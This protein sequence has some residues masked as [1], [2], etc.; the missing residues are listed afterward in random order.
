MKDSCLYLPRDLQ[1]RENEVKHR[2][3]SPISRGGERIE[4]GRGGEVA[5]ENSCVNERRVR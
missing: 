4:V 1:R 3:S 2:S 5:I